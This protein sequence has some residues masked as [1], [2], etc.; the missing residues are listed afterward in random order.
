MPFVVSLIDNQNQLNQKTISDQLKKQGVDKAEDRA[1]NKNTVFGTIN[2]ELAYINLGDNRDINSDDKFHAGVFD[3]VKNE[4]RDLTSQ[5]YSE[6]TKS[7]NE[8]NAFNKRAELLNQQGHTNNDYN[9]F[10]KYCINMDKS[11]SPK[12]IKNVSEIINSK[13]PHSSDQAWQTQGAT[14]AAIVRTNDQLRNAIDN[15]IKLN[16]RKKTIDDQTTS[17]D[18]IDPKSKDLVKN[19]EPTLYNLIE[20]YKKSL[21]VEYKQKSSNFS[22]EK[23]KKVEEYFNTGT[24]SLGLNVHIN[25]FKILNQVKDL[26]RS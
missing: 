11:I 26:I 15:E 23:Q 1:S 6:F 24:F 2:G 5:E 9:N 7:L 18:L 25:S 10:A 3:K 20:E 4:W 14:N 12:D 16:M 17:F 13:K 21:I 19:Q 22:R 8:K